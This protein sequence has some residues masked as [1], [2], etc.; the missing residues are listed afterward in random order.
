MI[1]PCVLTATL[2]LKQVLFLVDEASRK[3]GAFLMIPGSVFHSI[4]VEFIPNAFGVAILS[5]AYHWGTFSKVVMFVTT[6]KRE[7]L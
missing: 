3:R 2:S 6:N 7:A 5:S 4:I 1:R